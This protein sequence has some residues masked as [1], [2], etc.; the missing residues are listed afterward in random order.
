MSGSASHEQRLPP[1][2]LPLLYFGFAHLALITALGMVVLFPGRLAG[3]YYQP[4]TLAVVHL[5]TLGW[6]SSSILGAIYLIGPIALR[7][8]FP[9]RWPDYLAFV[10]VVVG[11]VGMAGHFWIDSYSGMVWSAGT[12]LLGL[13]QVTGRVALGLWDA[14]IPA[15]VKAHIVLAFVNLLLAGSVGALIGVEKQ[16]VHVLPG[17]LLGTVYGHA[18]LAALGW[19]TMMV[20]GTGYRLFPMVL[21]ASMPGGRRLWLTA[22]ILEVGVLG[23]LLTLPF[24]TRWSEPFALLGVVAVVLFLERVAWMRRHPKK[25]PRD[26]PMPDYGSLQAVTALVW[27][28]LA[29][30]LGGVLTLGPPGA[31]RVP[32]AGLYG[33]VGLVGFLAQI[34][35]GMEARLL[36]MFA[37]MHAWV[38]SGFEEA[39]P[40]PHG[41]AW[42]PLQAVTWLTWLVGVPLLGVGLALA[43]PTPLAA[44]AAALLVGLLGAGINAVR[45]VRHAF[46]V[47]A[48]SRGKAPVSA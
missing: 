33:V 21:P 26:L 40:S 17:Y 47:G 18:H 45:V 28:A 39:P 14:G 4:E 38:G 22:V 10:L 5:I 3:F 42:R 8:R 16:M 43:R 27:L 48:E 24:R 46:A 23:L 35:I 44:G 29:A 9:A 34:V 6:I 7:T 20:M 2:V 41:L 25:S 1:K 32:V 15:A 36:P 30:V 19:A 12:L 11:T 13:L 37:W 31:W